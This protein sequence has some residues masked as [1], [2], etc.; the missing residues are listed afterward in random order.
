MGEFAAALAHEINQPLT[1]IANYARLAKRAAEAQP[2]D[3]V[4][5]AEAADRAIAQVERAARSS[6]DC[7]ISFA[8]DIAKRQP[9]PLRADRRSPVALPC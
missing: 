2:A 9:F 1:A 5:A 6:A 7:A 4:A 3:T 8:L